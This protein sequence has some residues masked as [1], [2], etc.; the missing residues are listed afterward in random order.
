MSETFAS[1]FAALIN[2]S[3]LTITLTLTALCVGL[4]LAFLFTYAL[5]TKKRILVVPIKAFIQFTRGVPLIVQMFML[6]YGAAQFE[7]IRNSFLWEIVQHP[8][9]CASLVLGL[10]SS[11]YTT[12]LLQAGLNAIP[13]GEK[14]ACRALNMSKYIQFRHILFPRILGNFWPSYSNEAIMVLKSTSLAST[15]T[16]IDLMGA[17]RQIISSS[18]QTFETLCLASLIYLVLSS[19][20]VGVFHA[21][22]DQ[23]AKIQKSNI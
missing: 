21:L 10:N 16:L 19:L 17:A 15:I 9:F 7:W 14:D 23:S 1:N 4:I 8:F 18:Y 22:T 12:V 5:Y 6:Y 2:G 11:A 3:I 20:I 13:K